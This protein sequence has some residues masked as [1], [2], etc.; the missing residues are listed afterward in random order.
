MINIQVFQYN[1]QRAGMP[2]IIIKNYLNGTN[3][4]GNKN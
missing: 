4:K 2:H 3:D 1:K